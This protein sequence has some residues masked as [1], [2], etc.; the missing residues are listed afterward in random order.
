MDTIVTL[1]IVTDLFAAVEV[2]RGRN[3]GR[4]LTCGGGRGH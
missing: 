1:S 2:V 3:E 4:S